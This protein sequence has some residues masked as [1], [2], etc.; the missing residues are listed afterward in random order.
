MLKIKFHNSAATNIFYITP[1]THFLTIH[2]C[3]THETDM[4]HNHLPVDIMKIGVIQ[5]V[6][7]QWGGVVQT[8]N[9]WVHVACVAQISE[10]SESWT[11][12]MPNYNL[13]E[14]SDTWCYK[15]NWSLCPPPQKKMLW[16]SFS[17][18]YTI[19]KQVNHCD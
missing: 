12:L 1:L 19:A 13:F 6:V 18:I 11:L 4:Y 8:L 16:Y 15:F 2:K 10:A 5:K 7:D 17:L 9:C 14:N 3:T